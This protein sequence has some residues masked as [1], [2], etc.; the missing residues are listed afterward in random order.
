[1]YHQFF[2]GVFRDVKYKESEREEFEILE[3][4]NLLKA[5]MHTLIL[6]ASGSKR[7]WVNNIWLWLG[8]RIED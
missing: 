5:M 6:T 3:E 1:M 4:L 7:C 8:F 2:L